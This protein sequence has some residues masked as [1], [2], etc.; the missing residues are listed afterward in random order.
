[1]YCNPYH[2]YFYI[3]LWL[4]QFSCMEI[5]QLGKPV[6]PLKWKC[7]SNKHKICAYVKASGNPVHT[8]TFLNYNLRPNASERKKQKKTKTININRFQAKQRLWLHKAKS[9]ET[10]C[11]TKT[12]T[13][14]TSSH[15]ISS[16]KMRIPS[17][18]PKASTLCLTV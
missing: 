4:A 5:R 7:Y 1:M 11:V 16:A 10:F 2:F 17:A 9:L 13:P 15:N 3:Y 18:R 8:C 6:I 14:S 12:C